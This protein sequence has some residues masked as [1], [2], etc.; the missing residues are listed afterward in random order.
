M[1]HYGRE[2]KPGHRSGFTYF[3]TAKV[4]ELQDEKIESSPRAFY[5]RFETNVEINRSLSVFFL[6]ALTDYPFNQAR[7]FLTASFTN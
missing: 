6:R 5:V 3:P 7:R 4:Q 2:E 1:S